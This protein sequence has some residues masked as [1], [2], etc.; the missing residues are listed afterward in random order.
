VC[1]YQIQR[2]VEDPNHVLIDLEFDTPHQAQAVLTALRGVWAHV[3]GTLIA[4]PQARI[5]QPVE[6]RTYSPP[7]P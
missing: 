4:N 6:T 3:S 5:L 2:A 7:A 1:R